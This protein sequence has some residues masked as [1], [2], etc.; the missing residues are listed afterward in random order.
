MKRIVALTPGGPDQLTVQDVPVPEPGPGEVLI[1]IA[2]SGVNFIDAYFRGGLYKSD[3][4][5]VLGN[6]GAGVVE[7]TAADVTDLRAG[8]R[9][10]YAMHRGSYA[11]YA[12]VPARLVAKIPDAVDFATAAAVMLQGATAH[13]LTHSTFPLGP[14]HT[15]VVHAAAGGAGGLTVQMAK[16]RG[17]RVI[18]TTSTE[19]KAHEVRALGA[20]DV[21]VHETHD[22]EVEVKRLTDGRGVDVVYDSVG[23]TT[24]DRSLKVIRPRGTMVLFGQSSGPV[25]PIDLNILNQRGSLYVTRPSLA[26][27]LATRDE[28]QWRADEVFARIVSGALKVRISGTYGLDNIGDAHRAIESGKTTGKLV[29]SLS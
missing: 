18:G 17:A 21:I 16:D 1:R 23:K 3:L 27:Y 19:A 7:R 20:D 10:V 6:E 2:V 14:A 12:A 25:P 28:V 5:I 24:F 22:F 29:V 8:D 9:V 15:C 4:P 26:H 11:E 13:Y